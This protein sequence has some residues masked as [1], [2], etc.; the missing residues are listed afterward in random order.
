[1]LNSKR[2]NFD[3]IFSMT[4]FCV[5]AICSLFMVMIGATVYKNCVTTMESTYTSRTSLSYVAEKIRQ[6]DKGSI[7]VE[8][9]ENISVLKMETPYNNQVI[10]TYIYCYNGYLTELT[11]ADSS[12]F[13]LKYG[14]KILPFNDI[15]FVLNE[16]LITATFTS[17]DGFVESL[18]ICLHAEG[19]S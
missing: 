5:F 15:S 11:T 13:S 2:K 18:I 6:N 4:L 7:S 16:N 1:M 8:S 9:L 17:F 3:F 14:N 12:M 10:T 19:G